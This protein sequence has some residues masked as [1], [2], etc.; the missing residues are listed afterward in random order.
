MNMKTSKFIFLCI[1]SLP[2]IPLIPIH[3]EEKQCTH[4]EA[5]AA[6]KDVSN[7]KSWKD[8]YK[9][10]RKYGH[11]D[12]GCIAEG[13]SEGISSLLAN[14]WSSIQSLKILISKDKAFYSFVLRHIDATCD[15]EILKHIVANA[16]G[17][18]AKD[19]NLYIAIQK[20]AAAALLEQNELMNQK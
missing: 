8:A 7:L 5:I 9:S 16:K 15:T 1:F 14:S 11:C 20:A 4:E 2:F 10:F 12:D 6:E 13:Y 17:H 3:A 19:N 18:H